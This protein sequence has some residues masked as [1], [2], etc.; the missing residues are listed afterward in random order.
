VRLP[1]SIGPYAIA[2]LALT[3]WLHARGISAIVGARLERAPVAPLLA[4]APPPVAGAERSARP[5]LERNPFDSTTG[6]LVEGA[7][8]PTP[9][10]PPD[11]A[12][13]DVTVLAIAAAE[14]PSPSLALLR[15]KGDTEPRLREVGDEVLA[16][17][18]ESVVL[19]NEGHPCTARMFQKAPPK[20]SSV[21]AGAKAP[22]STSGIVST[23]P[24]SFA[25]DRGTR[26]ALIEGAADWGRSIAIRPEKVGD[27]IVG[28]RIAGMAG[29]TPLSALGLQQGDILESVGGIPLTSPEKI[30]GAFPSLRSAERL[31][32]VLKR[33]G[34]EMQ[35]DYAVR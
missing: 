24:G 18:V 5:I 35:L 11:L 26:D 12:C 25:V 19:A 2:A 29:G 34:R 1:R 10:A 4:A 7:S 32:L 27:D 21:A 14:G 30:L 16:I 17:G 31:T 9:D 6:P 15:M 22:P 28:L 33:A 8:A 20:P 13:P 23:S 3:A